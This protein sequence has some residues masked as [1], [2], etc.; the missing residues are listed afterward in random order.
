VHFGERVDFAAKTLK[1]DQN[2]PKIIGI[3]S[4]VAWKL[5]KNA[6]RRCKTCYTTY[7]Q[8]LT[9]I[10][11]PTEFI[12][13]VLSPIFALFITSVTAFGHFSTLTQTVIENDKNMFVGSNRSF[14]SSR[15]YLSHRHRRTPIWSLLNDL[16]KIEK[17]DE[18]RTDYS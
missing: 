9:S 3:N 6:R 7:M 13:A 10:Y 8:K 18:N 12:F 11:R 5:P 4:F 15:S 2:R 17:I 1:M 14:A 16:L